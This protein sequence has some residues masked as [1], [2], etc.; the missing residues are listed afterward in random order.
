MPWKICF[1]H[2]M[3]VTVYSDP[4]EI[5]NNRRFCAAYSAKRLWNKWPG[6][7]GNGKESNRLSRRFLL[8]IFSQ[9]HLE[10]LW[11]QFLKCWEWD[12]VCKACYPFYGIYKY[13]YTEDGKT[14]IPGLPY[15]TFS[16]I[17]CSVFP[18]FFYCSTCYLHLLCGIDGAALLQTMQ[19]KSVWQAHVIVRTVSKFEALLC[20]WFTTQNP[21]GAGSFG[22]TL[23]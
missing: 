21:S 16:C 18:A 15:L 22:C 8:F 17:C 20:A 19:R 1:W 13:V 9:Y 7:A 6:T 4:L 3:A 23:I 10:S 2:R 12:E 5:W 14:L 11:W